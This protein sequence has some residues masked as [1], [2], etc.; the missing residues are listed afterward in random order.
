[1]LRTTLL[2]FTPLILLVALT[3][4]PV[5]VPTVVTDTLGP[6]A[7]TWLLISI[8]SVFYPGDH[9]PDIKTLLGR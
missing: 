5:T 7:V 4:L 6:F 8:A 3:L 2:G 9:K 1:V